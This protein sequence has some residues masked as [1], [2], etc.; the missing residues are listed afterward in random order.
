MREFKHEFSGK[1]K[2]KLEAF[3]RK[4]KHIKLS[5]PTAGGK[6]VYIFN[7]TGVGT[8]VYVRCIICEKEEDI[9]DVENW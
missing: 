6:F 5:L 9:T 8:Y 4:H 7:P 2:K 3:Y 1:E